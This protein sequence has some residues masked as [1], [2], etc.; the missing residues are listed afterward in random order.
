MMN[1]IHNIKYKTAFQSKE[2]LTF[3]C[4]HLQHEAL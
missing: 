3:H 4:H 2:A 1:T